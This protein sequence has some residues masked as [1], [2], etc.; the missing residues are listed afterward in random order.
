MNWSHSL[1]AGTSALGPL[2]T[3]AFGLPGK[4]EKTLTALWFGFGLS[5]YTILK[6]KGWNRQFWERIHYGL[7]KEGGRLSDFE[8]SAVA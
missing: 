3:E 7:I 1:S 4:V 2:S 5:G 6:I 8:K